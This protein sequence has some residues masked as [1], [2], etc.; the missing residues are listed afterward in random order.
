MAFGQKKKRE[1][2]ESN[3]ISLM[4]IMFNLLIFVL[5]TAQYSNVS[6]LKVNLPKA[7]S[8]MSVEKTDNIVIAVTPSEELFLN[9][10][11]VSFEGLQASLAE[12]GKRK[13]QPFV[14]IQ[15]DE[16]TSTG[17]LVKLMDTASKSGL[18]KI[19]IETKK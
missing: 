5:V 3:T 12:A 6:A 16:K 10:K 17:Q 19:S 18:A 1:V 14:L 11:P 8:G 7:Q 15:A 4:D 2:L 9:G 13:K